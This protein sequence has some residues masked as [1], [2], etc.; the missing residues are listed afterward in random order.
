MRQDADRAKAKEMFRRMTAR[1]KARH[2][3]QYYWLHMLAGVFILIVT[4]VFVTDWRTGAATRDQLY[5][6]LQTDCYDLLRPQVEE[7]AQEAGWP[8]GLNFMSFPS[9]ASEDG[10]GSMQLAMYLTADQ[11]DFI[12]CDEYTMRLL[13]ADETM[14]CAAATFEDTYLGART[15]IEEDLFILTLY[16]TARAEKV[17]RFMPILLGPVS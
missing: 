15:D 14:N 17:E 8:E 3:F 7:L 12:V 2:I 16:D 13:T 11:L 4:V 5:I 1:E 10:M 6:G 9:A